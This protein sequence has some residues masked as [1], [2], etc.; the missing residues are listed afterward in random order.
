MTQGARRASSNPLP[1][2]PRPS[3]LG[4]APIAADLPPRIDLPGKVAIRKEDLQK[5][6]N[7]DTWFQLQHVD[8]DSEVQV[9]P[10]GARGT[11]GPWGRRPD[12]GYRHRRWTL[13]FSCPLRMSSWAHALGWFHRLLSDLVV[14]LKKCNMRKNA[15]RN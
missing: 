13:V 5:Y 3:I 12:C 2:S 1:A 14:Q 4:P 11:W 7:R 10:R 6:H 9:R 15:T 8:A